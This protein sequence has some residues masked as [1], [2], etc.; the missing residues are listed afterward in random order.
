M[1]NKSI[2][3]F[4]LAALVLA[5][6]EKDDD[7]PTPATPAALTDPVAVRLDS[8][9]VVSFP[10]LNDQG[11]YWDGGNGSNLP[12]IYVEV[13]KDNILL[14]TSAAVAS[15][16]PADSHPV[17]T[18]G[19]GALPINFGEG[20]NLLIKLYDDDGDP[21]TN[22]PDFIGQFYISDALGFFY[23]GDHAAGFSQLQVTGSNDVT[24]RLT[25]TFI[26]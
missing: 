2:I 20:T 16:N 15:A 7:P 26:Y 4:A 9:T 3:L 14:F 19:S 11:S 21:G 18:P 6:C 1:M 10:E 13:F 25:G 17:S 8:I 23:G 24:F 12:D 22:A 5:S